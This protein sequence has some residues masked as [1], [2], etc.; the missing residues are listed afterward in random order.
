MIVS[1]RDVDGSDMLY[2]PMT[3]D[4]MTE[5]IAEISIR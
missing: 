4:L 1:Q 3:S 5:L 2:I